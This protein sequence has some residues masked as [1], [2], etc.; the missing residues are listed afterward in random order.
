MFMC[1]FIGNENIYGLPVCTADSSIDESV[2]RLSQYVDK[3]Y[4]TDSRTI[5][6]VRTKSA[7]FTFLY[8][9]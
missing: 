5:V 8:N 2:T 4:I 6:Y 1:M 7:E 9:Q 3:N